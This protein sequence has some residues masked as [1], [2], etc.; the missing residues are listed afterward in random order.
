MQ[1]TLETARQ[2]HRFLSQ[3]LVARHKGARRPPGKAEQKTRREWNRLPWRSGII[4]LAYGAKTVEGKL[5]NQLALKFYVPRKVDE[6]RILKSHLVPETVDLSELGWGRIPTDVEV[7]REVPSAHA[8]GPGSPIA[9]FAGTAGTVALVVRKGA[10]TERLFLSCSHVLAFSGF[11]HDN[12]GIE[13]PVDTDSTKAINQV[14]TLL[15][16]GF[17]RLRADIVNPCDA[18]LARILTPLAPPPPGFP[19]PVTFRRLTR[20]DLITNPTRPLKRFGAVTG[21]QNGTTMGSI[22]A[23]PIVDL[24]GFGSTP[25]VIDNLIPYTTSSAHGDSGAAIADDTGAIIGIHIAGTSTFGFAL[26]IGAV[27]DTLDVR[28]V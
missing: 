28:P 22:G 6:S 20:T 10:T 1:V 14:G 25:V 13:S 26:S 8:V 11:A 7:L 19:N 17:S 16:G 9:H 12:D 15:P 5:T 24:P 23:F 2:C 18:A 3:F 27:I 4:G 21:V